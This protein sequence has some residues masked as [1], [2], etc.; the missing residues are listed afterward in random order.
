MSVK[1]TAKAIV[2]RIGVARA[3]ACVTAKSISSH[4]GETPVPPEFVWHVPRRGMIGVDE[5]GR[6]IYAFCALYFRLRRAY[7]S[8]IANKLADCLETVRNGNESV[9]SRNLMYDLIRL[10]RIDVLT[11]G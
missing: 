7:S 3:P 6:K 2:H 1:A 4:T 11:K 5:I 8:R 9:F 10:A